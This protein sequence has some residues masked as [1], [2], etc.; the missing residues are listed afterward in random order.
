MAKRSKDVFDSLFAKAEKNVKKISGNEFLDI[1]AAYRKYGVVGHIS[2]TLPDFDLHLMHNKERT[3]YGF[4]RGRFCEIHGEQSSYKTTLCLTLAAECLAMGGRVY[5]LIGEYDI[6]EAYIRA[7]LAKRGVTKD[8]ESRYKI[9]PVSTIG[10]MFKATQGIVSTLEDYADGIEAKGDSAAESLPPVLFVVDSIAALLSDADHEKHEKDFDDAPKMGSHAGDLHR[11]FKFFLEPV[12]RLGICYV[13]TNH[14]RA[15][16]G[17]GKKTKNPAHDSSIKY[18]MSVRMSLTA[19]NPPNN[20]KTV[21][22]VK[23]RKNQVISVKTYKLRSDWV[24]NGEFDVMY[25]HNH[26]FNYFESLL[27]ALIMT[28]IAKKTG[29][30]Y[31]IDQID[32]TGRFTV[33]EGVHS[34]KDLKQLFFENMNEAVVLGKLALEAG[35]V[36]LEDLRLE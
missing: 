9:M 3:S 8:Q 29:N 14:Y 13:M 21:Q 28:G 6:D 22:G 26:G 32:E 20:H 31:V 5:W 4:P 2:T 33:F 11:F 24:V 10:E 17:F 34:K 18:Y 7:E 23:L 19:W 16:L 1:D 35:P 30:E 27:N 12:A 36:Q 25:Q 15:N